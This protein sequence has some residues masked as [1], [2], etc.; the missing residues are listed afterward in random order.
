MLVQSSA[1]QLQSE[2]GILSGRALGERL[3]DQMTAHLRQTPPDSATPLDFSI[4]QFVDISAADEFLCKLL[5][6]IASGELGTRYVFI[7]G[8]NESIRE[9][10]EAVLK[11]RDLA[12]LCLEDEKRLILGVL[13]TPMR[14]ALEVMLK[15]RH[16]TSAELAQRLGKN[17][18]IACNRL[19]ALQKMGLVC[20]T[21]DGSVQGG[22]RQYYYEAI[23]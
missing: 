10:L 18:N 20:R 7:Q 23:V 14:E 5:M 1:Y 22:G 2:S 21:R 4:I 11:L 17:I 9:T 16:G 13:K 6:R 19:N 8:A 12:A 15:A 3:L